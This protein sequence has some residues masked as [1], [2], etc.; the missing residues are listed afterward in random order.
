MN[1]TTVGRMMSSLRRKGVAAAI[2]ASLSLGAAILA[3][4]RTEP[5]SH[6]GRLTHGGF[7]DFARG[8]FDNGGANLYVNA[9]GAVEM[10]HHWDVNHDGY[11]DLVLANT[12]D[13]SE[14]G[15]TVVFSPTQG[16]AQAWKRQELSAVSGWMSRI[17]DV[18]KD[19]HPDLVLA[20]GEDGV[21]S[22]L[23]SYVY[24]GGPQGLSSN[25]TS[26]ATVGA[27]DVAIGDLNHDGRLDLIFPAAWRDHH[28]AAAPLPIRVYLQTA[29][30]TF[31]DATNRYGLL[32]SACQ[33]IALT[34]LNN[35]GRLDLVAANARD[36]Y[37]SDT[38]SFIYWG[39]AE[40]FLSRQPFRLPT[41]A[42]QQVLAGDLNGD[43]AKDIVFLGGGEVR[44]YW[45]R[46]GAFASQDHTVLKAAGLSDQFAKAAVRGDIADLD[47]DGGNELILA[48]AGGVEI[49]PG[50][51]LQSVRQSLAITNANWVTAG[52]ADGDGRLDLVVSKRDDGSKYE[53]ESAIFWNSP[54][55]FSAARVKLLQ[56]SGAMGSAVGDLDG[57]AR[58]EVVFSNTKGGHLNG[59]PSYVYLGNR[60]ARYGIAHRLELPTSGTSTSV[61]VDLDLDGFSEMV[62][63]VH[64]GLRIFRGSAQG[65]RTES[66]VDLKSANASSHGVQ[67]ADF[68]RDGYLDLL[69]V[70]VVR[71]E[72]PA[73]HAKGSTIFF[74]S[75]KG[76][77]PSRVQ[78]LASYGESTYL[79]DLNQDGYVDI[80]FHDRRDLVLIY[81]GGPAGF[82][83]DRTIKLPCDVTEESAY[84]NVGDINKDG[85]VDLVVSVMGHRIRKPNTLQI[86]Y[87]GPQGHSPDRSERYLGNYSPILTAMADFNR[88][89]NLDLV[90]TGYSTAT[91][92]VIP[93]RLFWG[94]GK[95]FDFDHPLLLPASSSSA[96]THMDLNR[97][98]WI[99]LVLACHR[100]DAGHK[101]D[102]LIYWNSRNGF[103]LAN[104]TRLPGLGPHGMVAFDRGNVLTRQPE[105]HYVSPPLPLEGRPARLGWTAEVPAD[106]QLKFQLRWA[107]TESA[108]R[109]AT[110]TGPHGPA[111]YYETPG[112]VLDSVPSSV[113]WLQYRATFVALYGG[114]SPQLREVNIDLHANRATGKK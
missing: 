107:A 81:L 51:N 39:T 67:V 54:S 56:T 99:D 64:G 57:D 114:A 92:R 53:T 47:G 45:N 108:L 75:G 70:G 28:N 44:V 80:L 66:F 104:P 29:D 18:D 26:L 13:I 24:W 27:Y 98:G 3:Y 42:A 19:G 7:A 74:G 14:R 88:D 30:R 6:P 22:E 20:N 43:Q 9:K 34:D 62:F 58:P 109:D 36:G 25:R 97:D 85:W 101:V 91:G 17:A 100:N 31:A 76:F 23:S 103:D 11:P 41:H 46:K 12:H 21:T 79:A 68:N 77:H 78:Y 112:S 33:S 84:M 37:Q 83:A 90:T 8:Q 65:P 1:N 94:D 71:S 113:R 93:A 102:S 82:S 105:E 73:A 63:P 110:W 38:D 15:P 10:I 72:D 60:D 111:T 106:A 61:I 40:G 86:F 55:G 32:G 52:D 69:S 4:S 49:R 87:G 96:I 16:V 48:L 5:S 89:G 35:D 59:I 95:K 50:R 2:T